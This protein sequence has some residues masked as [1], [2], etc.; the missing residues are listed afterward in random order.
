MNFLPMIEPAL[1]NCYIAD[2]GG[3]AWQLHVWPKPDR[4]GCCVSPLTCP[5]ATPIA[6]LVGKTYNVLAKVEWWAR[7]VMGWIFVLLGAHFSLRYVF[8]VY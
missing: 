8:E 1:P 7:Q 3:L 4:A 6:Q 2:V 5:S